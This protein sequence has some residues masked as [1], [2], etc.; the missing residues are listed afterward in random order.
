MVVGEGGGSGAEND[1]DGESNPRL[2]EHGRLSSY[3]LKL[4][5]V[6]RL[7]SRILLPYRWTVQ[8]IPEGMRPRERLGKG[9][10]P[11]ARTDIEA[12]VL[13]RDKAAAQWGVAV[14][15]D[16]HTQEA[17]LVGDRKVAE[18]EAARLKRGAAAVWRVRPMPRPA[19]SGYCAQ[20][21]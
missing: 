15:Y 9:S 19:V 21:T 17:W 11:M 14:R 2:V 20:S 10:P 4:F 18:L 3:Q 1:R 6:A 5:S 13:P 7:R 8:Y 12:R 16:D